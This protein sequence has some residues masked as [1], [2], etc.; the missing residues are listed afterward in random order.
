MNPSLKL[1]VLNK[2]ANTPLEEQDVID[3]TLCPYGS[4]A[5]RQC[6]ERRCKDC[7]VEDVREV[8][9]RVL[10][11]PE[12]QTDVSWKRWEMKD[13]LGKRKLVKVEKTGSLKDLVDELLSELVVLPRHVLQKDWQR[14]QFT[15]SRD[16]LSPDEAILIMDWHIPNWTA[17]PN[18]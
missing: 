5:K 7:D 15:N 8:I 2:M 6:V 11:V 17:F 13:V 18:R 16:K 12:R 14:T 9:M 1:Q 10:R 4:F 3:A